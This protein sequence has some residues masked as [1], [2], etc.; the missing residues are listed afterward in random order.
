MTQETLPE[1]THY[2]D[3]AEVDAWLA[4]IWLKAQH[5][6]CDVEPLEA[7]GFT[8]QLGLRHMKGYRYVRFS[9]EGSDSFYAYWQPAPSAPAPLLVHT[10]GYGAEMSVHPD[11]VMQGYNVLHVN[12]LGY[13]TPSGADAAKRQDD[14]WPVFYDTLTSGG[15]RGYMDWFAQCVMAVRW[16]WR[17]PSVLPDRVS[18]FGTSQGGGASLLLGSLYQGR[19]ARC[20]ATDVPWLINFPLAKRYKPA[21]AETLFERLESSQQRGKGSGRETLA[22]Q[23]KHKIWR[24]MGLLDAR[25]HARRLTLPVLLTAGSEDQTCYPATIETLFEALP[26]TKAYC[27]LDGQGHGYT[28]AFIA[29][30]SAWFRLYA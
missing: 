20:V 7:Q 14:T 23:E 27:Y 18:F 11:L 3:D 8:E 9:P 30:A 22:Q 6:R 19:G 29:L 28:Q 15:E 21:W 5:T 13:V 10:P 26:T 16:A 2:P 1:F 24:A 4:R 17:Q 25:S 12:P